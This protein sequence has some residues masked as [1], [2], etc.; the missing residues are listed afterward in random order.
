MKN[1]VVLKNAY[2]ACLHSKSYTESMKEELK[3]QK[4]SS[5][6]YLNENQLKLPQKR[7]NELM[8]DN[9]FMA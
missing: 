3:H 5:F 4:L 9:F 6:V 1:S 2:Q 7:M 8:R